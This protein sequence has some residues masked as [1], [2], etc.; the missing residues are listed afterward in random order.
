MA[1]YDVEQ[2]P[3]A[4]DAGLIVKLTGESLLIKNDAL[5]EKIKASRS[6]R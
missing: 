5:I 2:R 4:L 3:V 1:L 6:E